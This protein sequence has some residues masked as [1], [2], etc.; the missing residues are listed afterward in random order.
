[1]NVK[2]SEIHETFVVEALE[3]G[4][5]NEK[6][7][8]PVLNAAKK[9]ARYYRNKNECNAHIIKEVERVSYSYSS[10]LVCEY[11]REEQ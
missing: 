10:E 1:M 5:W 8:T 6:Y 4:H 11:N 2:P 9:Q 3:N 7:R